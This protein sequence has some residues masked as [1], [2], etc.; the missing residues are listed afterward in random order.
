MVFVRRVR[1]TP[2]VVQGGTPG[3]GVMLDTGTAGALLPTWLFDQVASRLQAALR[4]AKAGS[5][6]IATRMT[7]VSTL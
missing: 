3:L 6:R 5:R 2:C 4:T 1:A 7:Y